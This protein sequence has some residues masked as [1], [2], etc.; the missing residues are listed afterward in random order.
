MARRHLVTLLCL[1]A[2]LFAARGARA[3]DAPPH[4]DVDPKVECSPNAPLA[5]GMLHD[6]TGVTEAELRSSDLTFAA[7][8]HV[9]ALALATVIRGIAPK[10]A[11]PLLVKNLTVVGDL[12]LR[13]LGLPS[14]LVLE[15]VR[16]E[17]ALLL[18]DA[19]I[20]TVFI[21]NSTVTGAT[22]VDGIR[23]VRSFDWTDGV[24]C[25]G[26][27]A[28]RVDV[29][30]DFALTDVDVCA[31]APEMPA[32]I[33][34]EYSGPSVTVSRSRIAGDLRFTRATA[35]CPFSVRSVHV[36]SRV[37]FDRAVFARGDF[38]LDLRAV[39]ASGGT[40][41]FGS[42]ARGGVECVHLVGEFASGQGTVYEG[43]VAFVEF[44]GGAF[45]FDHTRFGGSVR[46]AAMNVTAV[47][48]HHVTF[49]Q[50]ALFVANKSLSAF[51]LEDVT[52]REHVDVQGLEVG[53]LFVVGSS[54]FLCKDNCQ[55]D[56]DATDC[57][58]NQFSGVSAKAGLSINHNEM[59]RP[60]VVSHVS[61]SAYL[62]LVADKISAPLE[63][64]SVHTTGSVN[65]FQS[66][67]S[68]P[69]S[70]LDT[71]AP[72]MG[73]EDVK[74]NIARER[75]RMSGVDFE[76]LDFGPGDTHF[77]RVFA[78]VDHIGFNK[79]IYRS[80]S[81]YLEREGRSDLSREILL[82]SHR[83]ALTEGPKAAGGYVRYAWKWLLY[84]TIG[85]GDAPERAF[86]FLIGLLFVGTRVYRVRD[87]MIWRGRGDAPPYSAFWYTLDLLLPII[88]LEDARDWFP[89]PHQRG[90]MFIARVFRVTG[91]VLIPLL[92]ASL[93]GLVK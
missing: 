68:A 93:T 62:E 28:S 89:L 69:I 20:R 70:L 67:I 47:E 3:A 81:A 4:V 76:R 88:K 13:D 23:V 11:T 42:T 25:K 8:R 16:V 17:G 86:F 84:I 53:T 54:K 66:E 36:G 35:E 34:A 90:R 21:R 19:D 5:S 9:D 71:K 82:K 56:P 91:F 64:F 24:A 73:F 41:L 39:D 57:T 87:R 50:D 7:Q 37:I 27:H 30:G 40:Y 85:G 22:Q 58:P 33:P 78:F 72:Q 43:N 14:T 65:F 83:R 61:Q 46:V 74:W 80:A 2:A 92:L 51:V 10:R 26:L 77:D 31:V 32:R 49:E 60:M 6:G 12:D 59:M 79:Q 18:T 63:L 15:N 44:S 52:F 1:F 55:C 45:T 38:S 29:G 48:M 75:V